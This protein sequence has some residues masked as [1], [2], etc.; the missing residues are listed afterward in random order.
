M[1]PAGWAAL[2]FLRLLLFA[3][4]SFALCSSGLSFRWR[5]R[6]R[7]DAGRPL[8]LAYLPGI[9]YRPGC[10]FIDDQQVSITRRAKAARADI[11]RAIWAFQTYR[12]PCCICC[13]QCRATLQVKGE[14]NLHGRVLLRPWSFF[15]QPPLAR[16]HPAKVLI[17][18]SHH[19]KPQGLR[20]RDACPANGNF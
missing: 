4:A 14:L 16:R 13:I 6:N 12:Q 8:G 9:P 1:L 15:P 3:V 10:A 7:F 18:P 19:A 2:V 11:S 5:G 17:F 20:K